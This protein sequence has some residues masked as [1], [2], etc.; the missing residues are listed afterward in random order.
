MG[1]C[2]NLEQQSEEDKEYQRLTARLTSH[3]RKTKNTIVFSQ[4]S[5]LEKKQE[6]LK[7]YQ[8]KK[9][10]GQGLF[11][12]VYYGLNMRGQE[13]ALKIIKKK[14]FTSKD[15][16]HKILIEKDIMKMLHHKNILKLYKTMQSNSS[17]FF[18]IE[19]CHYGSLLNILNCKFILSIS[20]IRLILAQVIDGLLYM[21]SKGIVYGDLKS[22]NI[23]INEKGEIKLCDFNL[24]GTY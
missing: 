7:N 14:N 18:E 13:V 12:E 22:E 23:L 20:D 17:L 24:S 1:N 16:I 21:H 19:Y 2:Y 4:S 15:I 8:I 5:N 9:K 6:I 3:L 10:L 11:S